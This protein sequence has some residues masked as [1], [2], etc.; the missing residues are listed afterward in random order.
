MTDSVETGKYPDEGVTES[1]FLSCSPKTRSVVTAQRHYVSRTSSCW[2]RQEMA[3]RIV[4]SLTLLVLIVRPSSWLWE[5]SLII[6]GHE[7]AVGYF[8]R[9]P[10]RPLLSCNAKPRE[11]LFLCHPIPTSNR[12]HSS[13]CYSILDHTKRFVCW[14]HPSSSRAL[15]RFL[16]ST[17]PG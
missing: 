2:S 17:F 14:R 4:R 10:P 9:T 8:F 7:D 5:A 3:L 16:L 15:P 13:P 12:K 1:V 6:C 11:T